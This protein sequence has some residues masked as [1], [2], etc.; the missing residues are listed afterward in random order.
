MHHA[1][2]EKLKSLRLFGMVQALQKLIYDTHQALRHREGIRDALKEHRV[3]VA[4]LAGCAGFHRDD[5]L[6]GGHVL[7]RK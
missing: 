7:S 6:V 5:Y 1:N 2:L 3:D 4:M